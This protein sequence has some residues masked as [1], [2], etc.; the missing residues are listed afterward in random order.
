MM[1]PL[2]HADHQRQHDVREGADETILTRFVTYLGGPLFGTQIINDNMMYAKVVVR[3]G[4]RTECKNCDFSD[5]LED[6]DVSTYENATHV[7]LRKYVHQSL[8][9]GGLL[10]R[11]LWALGSYSC[12][13]YYSPCKHHIS[14]S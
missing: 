7:A 6:E 13:S 8:W 12:F 5:I 2:R 14:Q 11:V 4:V 1:V 9:V 3:M 10:D